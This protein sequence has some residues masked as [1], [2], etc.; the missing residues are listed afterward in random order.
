[1]TLT[2]LELLITTKNEQKNSGKIDS[3]ILELLLGTKNEQRKIQVK[4]TQQQF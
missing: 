1:M 2:F 3:D 4:L